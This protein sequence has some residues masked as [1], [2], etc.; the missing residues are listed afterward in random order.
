MSIPTEFR[1]AVFLG[2]EGLQS[3]SENKGLESGIHI[4]ATKFTICV[5][6]AG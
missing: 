2:G 4:E 3:K 1:S 6:K 5:F